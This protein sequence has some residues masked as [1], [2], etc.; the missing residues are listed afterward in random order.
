MEQQAEVTHEERVGGPLNSPDETPAR[1]EGSDKA[2]QCRDQQGDEQ[3]SLPLECSLDL[4]TTADGRLHVHSLSRDE[5]EPPGACRMGL[6]WFDSEEGA[7]MSG[8][9]TKCGRG[10]PPLHA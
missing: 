9:S 2:H 1:Y 10:A 6:L 4:D 7:G 3:S 5:A 8:V